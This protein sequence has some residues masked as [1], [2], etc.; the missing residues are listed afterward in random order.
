M[1]QTVSELKQGAGEIGSIAKESTSTL[2]ENLKN[3]QKTA[4][5]NEVVPVQV[6][7][8]DEVEAAN[9]VVV[10]VEPTAT[11]PSLADVQ[12][13]EQSVQPSVVV[14]IEEPASGQQEPA[15]A[16]SFADSLKALIGQM[17]RSFQA[18]EAYATLQ[19][20]FDK[21][22]AQMA[23]LDVKLTDRYGDRY[24]KFKQEFNRDVENTKAW[25]EGMRVDADARGMN[26][27]E[28]KQ[29]ELVIKMG[30]AGVTIAQ[31]EAKIKQL[32]KELWQ[33]ATK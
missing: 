7:I 19:Q 29:A 1:T 21:L 11:E 27:I 6:E 13:S 28:Y 24:G 5:Q 8:H 31:K 4:S 33:T 26:V 32:L 25:Y 3:A 20:Q 14:M 23:I 22:K 30:E 10:S 9:L 18:G 15:T 2:T 17:V 12:P 16:E